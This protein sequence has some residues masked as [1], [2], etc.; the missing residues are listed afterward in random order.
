MK[1][2]SGN[3]GGFSLVEVALALAI[4]A[5]VLITTISLC[6]VA[7][8]TSKSVTD[9]T[10]V[11]SMSSNVLDD[12]RRQ[13]FASVQGSTAF[14]N[15]QGVRLQDASGNDLAPSAALSAGATYECDTTVTA[16]TATKSTDGTVNLQRLILK[17]KWPVQAA[18]APNI[19]YIYATLAND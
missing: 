19:K 4:A 18:T 8:A 9:D 1:T 2:G 17:F 6:T 3:C 5:F 7:V 16:D 14:F 13:P 12:Y 11:A 15:A 10:L